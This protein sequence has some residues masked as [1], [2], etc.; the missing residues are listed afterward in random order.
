M[1]TRFLEGRLEW[2]CGK[3]NTYMHRSNSILYHAN[4]FLWLFP[5]TGIGEAS[6][7]MKLWCPSSQ[8]AS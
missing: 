5:R 7:G 3:R 4:H 8:R 1:F 2:C 6:L